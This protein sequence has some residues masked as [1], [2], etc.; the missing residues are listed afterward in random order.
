MLAFSG[1][2]V[3]FLF[4]PI[5]QKY[6]F[7]QKIWK[8]YEYEINIICFFLHIFYLKNRL[9]SHNDKWGLCYIADLLLIFLSVNLIICMTVFFLVR[10]NLEEN[11]NLFNKSCPIFVAYSLHANGQDSFD[12]LYCITWIL[13]YWE[14][15]WCWYFPLFRLPSVAFVNQYSQKRKLLV[16]ILKN[17]V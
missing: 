16:F 11:Y 15:W 2:K 4:W 10:V 13:L 1:A 3:C 14:D 9:L 6:C 7:V 8:I 12:I 17:C 5:T